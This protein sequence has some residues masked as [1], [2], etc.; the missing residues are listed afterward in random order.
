MK[1]KILL[2]LLNI[3]LLEY[4]NAND[5]ES[6]CN[7]N[8]PTDIFDCYNIQVAVDESNPD[9]KIN[10]NDVDDKFKCCYENFRLIKI[11][12]KKTCRWIEKDKYKDEKKRL[13]KYGAKAV[14][15]DCKSEYYF[16]NNFVLILI[17]FLFF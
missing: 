12:N 6:I 4:N 7:L 8:I 17:I 3:I 11:N 10:I 14:K 9:N 13:K 2:L 16:L 5:Y 15:V 1:Q